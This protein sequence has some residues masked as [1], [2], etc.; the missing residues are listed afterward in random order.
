[1]K[2]VYKAVDE[3][4]GEISYFYFD[5]DGRYTVLNESCFE[6]EEDCLTYFKKG[7]GDWTDTDNRRADMINPVLIAEW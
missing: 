3:V 7:K 6:S 5:G 4:D 1:M 2:Q